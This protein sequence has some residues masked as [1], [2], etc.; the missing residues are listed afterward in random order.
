MNYIKGQY[1]KHNSP[2]TN[3]PCSSVRYNLVFS[4]GKQILECRTCIHEL[5]Q[6]QKGK[7]VLR[8]EDIKYVD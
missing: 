2:V 8:P 5:I 4:S 7:N 3:T 6:N 1:V